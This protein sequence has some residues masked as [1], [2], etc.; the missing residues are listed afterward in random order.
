MFYVS[1]SIGWGNTLLAK[2]IN[3]YVDHP[4][5]VNELNIYHTIDVNNYT[6]ANSG[7]FSFIGNLQVDPT[8]SPDAVTSKFGTNPIGEG[9]QTPKKF[10]SSFP[11]ARLGFEV[12]LD[13]FTLGIA[14]ERSSSDMDGFIL[15]T[16]KSVYFSLGYKFIR[17]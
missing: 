7:L 1:I 3:N 16:Y 8:Q 10:R 6:M 2:R 13:K 9:W 11:T 12:G 4:D 15:N 5:G 17:R 14:A